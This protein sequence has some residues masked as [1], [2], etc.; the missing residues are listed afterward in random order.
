MVPPVSLPLRANLLRQP[1]VPHLHQNLHVLQL[2]V[3]RLAAICLTL[4]SLPGCGSPVGFVSS[5]LLAHAVPASVEMLSPVLIAAIRSQILPSLRSW[6]SFYFCMWRSVFLFLL[7]VD[8]ARPFPQFLSSACLDFRTISSLKISFTPLS[9]SAPFALFLLLRGTLLRCFLSVRSHLWTFIIN[10]PPGC[11]YEGSASAIFGHVQACG[12]ATGRFLQGDA[13]SLSYLPEFVEKTESEFNPIPQPFLVCSLSQFVGDLPEQRLLCPMDAVR[14]YLALTSS[15]S[16]RPSSLFSCQGIPLVL[17]P[18]TPCRSSCAEL[19]WTLTLFG[20]VPLLEP[21]V[22][23]VWQRLRHSWRTGRSP[24]CLR[25]R[26]GDRI[27]FL[28][29]FIFV[30]F[31]FLWL[32][33]ALLV[34]SLLLAPSLLYFI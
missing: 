1:H 9:W 33:A 20:R 4:R 8:T 22:F 19:S 17:C 29:H 32:A 13:L 24:G 3:W 28:P 31:H 6:I 15:V 23:E 30:V 5:I 7:S 34:H 2:H 25:W 26:L 10:N 27:W 12:G 16:R 21:T 18:R 14:I 11:D